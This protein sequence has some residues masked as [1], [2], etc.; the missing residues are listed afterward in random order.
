MSGEM[1]QPYSDTENDYAPSDAQYHGYGDTLPETLYDAIFWNP[2]VFSRILLLASF[3]S[4]TT[5]RYES[6]L[7]ASFQAPDVEQSLARLHLEVFRTWLMHSVRRQAAD[8]TTYL[9]QCSEMKDIRQLGAMGERS[10]PTGAKPM[11]IEFF[12]MELK[13]VQVLVS[14]DRS[15]KG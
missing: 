10:I 7:A 1:D 4:S 12:L 8:I 5:G 9:N 3:R 2:S 13:I 11:E 14:Y 6:G 15:M